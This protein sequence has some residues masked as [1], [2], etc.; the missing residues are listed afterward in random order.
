[1]RVTVDTYTRLI[2]TAITVLLTVMAVG[3]WYES[4]NA[5]Q[6]ASAQI[7]D[8]GQQLAVLI[9]NAQQMNRS[10]Q[11]INKMLVSGQVK[12]QVIDPEKEKARQIPQ[13]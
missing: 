9:D 11:E 8:Q 7:P 6:A 1:M 5:V 10:L 2:L 3:L 12:V 4:P 13:Q